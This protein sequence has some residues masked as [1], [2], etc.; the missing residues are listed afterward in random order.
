MHNEGWGAFRIFLEDIGCSFH[1][2]EKVSDRALP[3]RMPQ[4]SLPYGSGAFF[5][6]RYA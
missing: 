2:E 3:L 1:Y 6:T 5:P 4:N